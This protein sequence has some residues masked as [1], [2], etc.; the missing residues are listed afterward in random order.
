MNRRWKGVIDHQ[1]R[2]RRTEDTAGDREDKK[3]KEDRES[4]CKFDCKSSLSIEQRP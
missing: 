4:I 2:V 3:D 1:D